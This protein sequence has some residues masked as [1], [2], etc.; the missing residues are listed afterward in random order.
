[1]DLARELKRSM[2]HENDSDTNCN[3]CARKDPPRL[4]EVPGRFRDWKTSRDHPNY[5]IV[6]IDQNT[7]KSLRELRGLGVTQLPFLMLV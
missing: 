7:E 2:E 4:G 1:M 6:K 5:C 3:W